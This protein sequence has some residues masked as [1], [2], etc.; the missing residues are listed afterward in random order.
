[1]VIA[2]WVG[3]VTDGTIGAAG[4]AEAIVDSTVVVVVIASGALQPVNMR[5][6]IKRRFI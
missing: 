2:S 3:K 6:A 5:V 4:S 1:M